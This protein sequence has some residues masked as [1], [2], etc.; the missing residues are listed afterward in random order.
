MYVS[1]RELKIFLKKK[2]KFVLDFEAILLVI[3]LEYFYYV[4]KDLRFRDIK[5]YV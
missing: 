2:W 1:D 5:G 3:Y 4:G